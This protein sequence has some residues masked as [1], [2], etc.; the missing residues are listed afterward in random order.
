MEISELKKQ[1][2][3]IFD[4]LAAR[5]GLKGPVEFSLSSSD[6]HFGYSTEAIG[7]E[8][9]VDMSDFFIYALIYKPTGNCIPIGYNDQTGRRQKLYLQEALKDLS[10][11]TNKETEALQKLA[12]D[13]LNCLKMTGILARLLE[14]NWP[15]LSSN[16]QRW[17]KT[18]TP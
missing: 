17:F 2:R 16:S 3:E 10:I 12:G 13:Y 18:N 1:I 7:V 11:Q 6:F 5:L 15:Q 8:L 4:P 9:T 14:Q